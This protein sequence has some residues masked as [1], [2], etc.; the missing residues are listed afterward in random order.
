MFLWLS[1][2]GSPDA[3]TWALQTNRASEWTPVAASQEDCSSTY[4]TELRKGI[5]TIS[6]KLIISLTACHRW[7]SSLVQSKTGHQRYICTLTSGLVTVCKPPQFLLQQPRLNE[8]GW[9]HTAN[10]QRC[11]P[12]LSTL[13]LSVFSKISEVKTWK[14]W[15]DAVSPSETLVRLFHW[16]HHRRISVMTHGE[17]TV[18]GLNNKVFAINS[19]VINYSDK[20][21]FF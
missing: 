10:K 16:L 14:E 1:E 20:Q 21:L 8:T 6:S 13:W 12:S 9:W 7:S 11:F 17:V 2:A 3:E 19:S 4:S 5:E 18:C 15:N